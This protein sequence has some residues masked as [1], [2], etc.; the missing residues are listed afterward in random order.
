MRVACMQMLDAS[1]ELWK[2]KQGQ[3][4]ATDPTVEEYNNAPEIADMGRAGVVIGVSAFDDFFTRRFAECIVPVIKAGNCNK[5]MI[6][7]LG[8]CGLD[9]AQSLALLTMNKPYRRIRKLVDDRL[10]HKTTQKFKKIDALFKCFKFHS[11]SADVETRTGR[12]TLKSSCKKIIDR[13]HAISHQGDMNK[14]GRLNDF[15]YIDARKRL[16]HIKL[17]IDTA[18]QLI[19]E[20]IG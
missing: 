3:S 11:L 5:L 15:S 12:S 19:A 6:E 13:R 10:E 2:T 9:V 17:F 7:F 8:E 1:V 14:H 20:K 18:N 16:G 4:D